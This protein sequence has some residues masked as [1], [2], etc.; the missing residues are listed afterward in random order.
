MTTPPTR[1][2]RP[3]PSAGA[4]WTTLA[5]LLAFGL[6]QASALDIERVGDHYVITVKDLLA[7]PEVYQSE[8]R[9]R[10]LDI[11]L[12]VAPTSAGN[13]RR[14]FVLHDVDSPAL[15]PARARERPHHHRR[16]ARPVPAARRLRD[17]GEGPVDYAKKAEIILGR[18]A[19]LGEKYAIPPGLAMPGEPLHCVAFVN[20]SL[21][22]VQELLRERGVRA[23]FISNGQRRA[24][25]SAPSGCYVLD[26]V[27]SAHGEPLLLVG[28]T[29][30]PRLTP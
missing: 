3:S 9:D 1:R 13:A 23:R 27:M 16:R 15:G 22:E 7:D 8:L 14:M 21:A 19:M 12:R 24:Q 26:G 29:P 6:G 11:T 20:R 2:P 25:D 18:Q 10:G 4:A 5:G 30:N 17:R 28:S